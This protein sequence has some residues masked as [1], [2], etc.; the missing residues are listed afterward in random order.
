MFKLSYKCII[1]KIVKQSVAYT[2]GRVS[3][4]P[5]AGRGRVTLETNAPSYHRP[6]RHT[7]RAAAGALGFA[8]KVP[9]GL[10]YP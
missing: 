3:P 6:Q 1:M 2:R 8:T 10:K 4:V 9:R 7:T 5:R